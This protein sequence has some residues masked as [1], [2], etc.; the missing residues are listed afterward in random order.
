MNEDGKAVVRLLVCVV[1]GARFIIIIF[2]WFLF[3]ERNEGVSRKVRL[4]AG[5][6]CKYL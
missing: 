1:C 5:A 2:P 4:P 3:R 6:I